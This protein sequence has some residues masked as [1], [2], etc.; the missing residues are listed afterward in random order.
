VLGAPRAV[1]SDRLATLVDAGIL[2][3]VPY[4]AEGERT[5]HEYR[6]TQKGL[7]LYPALVALMEW[8]NRY[9]SDDGTGP[10]ELRHRDCGAP[11]HLT[12]VCEDGHRVPGARGVRPEPADRAGT[13]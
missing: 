3:R 1:L 13:A 8:G 9:L 12:L 6:L 11:V 7:D 4:Q 2:A 5:R 10:L